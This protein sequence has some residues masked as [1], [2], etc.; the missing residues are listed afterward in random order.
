[1]KKILC[2][3]GMFISISSCTLQVHTPNPIVVVNHSSEQELKEYLPES[4]KSVGKVS[5]KKTHD[6]GMLTGTTFAYDKDHLLTAGHVC[7]DIYELQIKSVLE[8]NIKLSY[9]LNGIEIG[10]DGVEILEI[11]EPDDICLMKLKNHGL[12]PLKIADYSTVKRQD[13]II[14]V[15]APFGILLYA[16][17]GV[18]IDTS[19][20]INSSRKDRLI[21]SAAIAGGNSG[22]PVLNGNNEV[23][24]LISMGHTMFDHLGVA[25]P[26]HKISRFLKLIGK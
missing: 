4:F 24:G 18:V 7:V 3:L 13:E 22:S 12:K 16:E 5:V 1:M 6:D 11:D 26:S 19:Y 17:K 10:L 2:L 20:D 15:G 9:L 21:V 8:E 14:V 23:I 25:I